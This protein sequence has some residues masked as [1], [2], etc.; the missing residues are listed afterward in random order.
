MTQSGHFVLLSQRY[1][2]GKS[3]QRRGSK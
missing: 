1:R 3:S 2:S